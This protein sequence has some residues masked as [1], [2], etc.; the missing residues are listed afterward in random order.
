MRSGGLSSAT[1][2]PTTGAHRRV[3]P[4]LLPPLAVTDL[5]RHEED[6]EVQPA[7]GS[8][9]PLP[10]VCLHADGTLME[11]GQQGHQPRSSHCLGGGCRLLA[12]PSPE[13][14]GRGQ[15]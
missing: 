11:L 9:R 8:R 1:V 14:K 5:D 15:G 7:S 10:L 13:Y 2:V 4:G 12:Q 3:P 6:K